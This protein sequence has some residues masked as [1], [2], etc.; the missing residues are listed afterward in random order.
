MS[1]ALSYLSEGLDEGEIGAFLGFHDSPDRVTPDP[2]FELA[3]LR[4]TSTRRDS[5][6]RLTLSGCVCR[7]H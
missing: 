7:V 5:R 6:Y 4:W 2:G 3:L 1:L